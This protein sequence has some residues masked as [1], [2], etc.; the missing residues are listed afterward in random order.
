[1]AW[2]SN[3]IKMQYQVNGI[4]RQDCLRTELHCRAVVAFGDIGLTTTRYRTR[5]SDSWISRYKYT[6]GCDDFKLILDNGEHQGGN[7]CRIEIQDTLIKFLFFFDESF[8]FKV[9]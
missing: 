8:S 2:A 4:S 9:S 1:L 6:G 5:Y 3:A 7:G